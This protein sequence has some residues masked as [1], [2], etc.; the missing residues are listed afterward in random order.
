MPHLPDVVILRR[1][2]GVMLL[3]A[4]DLRGKQLVFGL[5]IASLRHTAH[6]DVQRGVRTETDEHG[7]EHI[8]RTGK[9]HFVQ[10]H[11]QPSEQQHVLAQRK[12]QIQRPLAA[13]QPV[14]EAIHEENQ[15]PEQKCVE[16]DADRVGDQ[17]LRQGL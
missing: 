6:G 11:A 16:A 7:D 10:T 3:L 2:R 13:V 14:L 15:H 5:E 1:D 17:T 8:E 9:R 12:Q 4:L